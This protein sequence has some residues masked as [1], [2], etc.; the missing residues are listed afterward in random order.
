MVTQTWPCTTHS[1]PSAAPSEGSSAANLRGPFVSL[2]H[3]NL[4]LGLDQTLENLIGAGVRTGPGADE[5]LIDLS[6][7]ALCLIVTSTV[8]DALF[9]PASAS[10]ARPS[11]LAATGSSDGRS[12]ADGARTVAGDVAGYARRRGG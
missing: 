4:R 3:T 12:R 11:D 6:H 8:T 2:M 1:G 10:S 9:P 5:R 7:K